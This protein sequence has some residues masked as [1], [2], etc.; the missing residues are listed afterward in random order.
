MARRAGR[1][2]PGLR[3]RGA[4]GRAWPR[5]LPRL[6][7]DPRAAGGPR[8]P[9]RSWC[10]R[11]HALGRRRL[12]RARRAPA[13][14]APA[15]AGAARLR[16]P[17]D[18]APGGWSAAW[19]AARDARSGRRASAAE[20]RRGRRAGRRGLR[21]RRAPRSSAT[22]AATRSTSRA[23]R[24]RSRARLGAGR[25]RSPACRR[26][27]PAAQRARRDRAEVDAARPPAG[28]CSTGAAVLGEP[29]DRGRRGRVAE[30]DETAST[31]LDELLGLGLVRPGD[32]PGRFVFRHPIVR[33]AVY[34]SA[35]VGFRLARRP[36]RAA[37]E[38]RGRA[39]GV[40]AHH[41]ERSASRRRR[42]RRRLLTRAAHASVPRT[43]DTAARWY[44]RA[45]HL[46]PDDAPAQR[47]LALL[48]P[49]ARRSARPVARR[50]EPRRR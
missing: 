9:A 11:R 17:P 1:R 4:G 32:A 22:A 12:G 3:R 20:P 19:T 29:F 50:G 45:L 6:P 7:G 34:V 25:I 49:L 38:R 44:S 27:P 21:R 47:R 48:M 40:L 8:L 31:A 2:L 26:R 14:P 24:A 46:L 28:S 42:A 37:L 13:A 15:R 23:A 36:R 41:V 10:A 39:A 33:R 18:R 35:G 5:A 30:L 43:P 16:L